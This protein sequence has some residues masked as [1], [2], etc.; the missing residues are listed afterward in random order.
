MSG[1]TVLVES[2]VDKFDSDLNGA[3]FH[4]Q[5]H[6][7]TP[8]AWQ[9]CGHL[10][11]S[12]E[13]VTITL[14]DEFPFMS[15]RVTLP[16]RDTTRSWHA[17]PHTGLCLWTPHDQGDLPWLDVPRLIARIEAWVAN[18]NAGWP[19]D[20]PDLDLERYY[21]AWRRTGDTP[22]LLV[23]EDWN[24]IAGQWTLLRLVGHGRMEPV[25][26]PRGSYA[27]LRKKARKGLQRDYVARA[28]DLGELASPRLTADILLRKMGG[29]DER[30]ARAVLRERSL[31]VLARYLRQ[32]QAAYVAFV[33]P[34]TRVPSESRLFAVPTAEASPAVLALRG[35]TARTVL[36]T[37]RV[38]IIGLG[39][40]G[41]FM[42][43]QLA[44]SGIK[45][46]HLVDHDILRP[47]NLIRHRSGRDF[48]GEAKT[49]AV[50]LSLE[51][52]RSLAP[53]FSRSELVQ[54]LDDAAALLREYDLV[55]NATGDRLTQQTLQYA[56]E[57][58]N[59]T[60]LAVCVEGHGQ[61]ARAD[62]CPPLQGAKPLSS[63][64]VA[65]IDLTLREGGCGDPVS[66][67]PPSICIEAACI[68]TRHAMGLLTGQ[69]VHAA[70]ERRAMGA[71]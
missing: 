18:N 36:A 67:T 6:G 27:S 69:P 4:T 3:G 47:G 17:D 63:D 62:V 12:G 16:D 21:P 7:D 29:G 9:W 11:A 58:L 60:F 13:K 50:V 48:V 31:V 51:R 24:R 38:A 49:A 70:G 64:G 2:T 54:G 57:Q 66:P 65:H 10:P 28:V 5:K 32:E 35:G 53:T 56:A 30:A 45:H 23:L 25:D 14:P 37:K 43:D 44:R 1:L 68:G 20:S 52:D 61:Y 71:A 59:K 42:A 26:R 33:I 55:I 46:L 22:P 41:S 19:D 39:A 8:A 40:V 34:P 15:P